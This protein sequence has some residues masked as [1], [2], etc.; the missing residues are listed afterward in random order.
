LKCDMRMLV[1]AGLAVWAL[2]LGSAA[3]AAPRWTPPLERSCMHAMTTD[4]LGKCIKQYAPTAKTKDM[5]PDLKVIND[6]HSGTYLFVRVADKWRRASQMDDQNYE[7]LSSTKLKYHGEQGR[8]VEL[9]HVIEMPHIRGWMRERIM[10][11]CSATGQC[12]RYLTAC[13]VMSEGR[14]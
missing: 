4:E 7:L 2:V 11:V 14:A 12:E 3:E 10:F 9:G 1:V 5:S 8:R 13:T 6:P